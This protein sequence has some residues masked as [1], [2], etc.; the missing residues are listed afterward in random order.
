MRSTLP[1]TLALLAALLLASCDYFAA[2]EDVGFKA[3]LSGGL[4]RTLRGEADFRVRSEQSFLFYHMPTRWSIDFADDDDRIYFM[5]RGR[6]RP[7][8]DRYDVGAFE[9]VYENDSVFTAFMILDDVEPTFY[10]TGGFVEV[11]R[12]TPDVV[13]GTFAF[14]ALP[15]DTLEDPF[16]E[17][18]VEGFFTARPA[19]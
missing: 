1:K 7:E 13:E 3:D 19:R 2:D 8:V 18:R 16:E 10:T 6:E 15:A 14:T 5:R 4:E 11:T 12:S 9:N 17:V